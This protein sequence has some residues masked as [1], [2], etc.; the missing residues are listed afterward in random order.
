MSMRSRDLR[1]GR[2]L[3]RSRIPVDAGAAR[4]MTIRTIAVEDD[5]RYRTS[6]EILLEHAPEFQLVR[7]YASSFEAL[8]TLEAAVR[9][10]RASPWD[11]VLMDLDLPQLGGIEC[12]R[13]M[14]AL[15]PGLTIVV[16]TVLDQEAAILEAIC[17]GADGY[18]VKR[19]PA[20]Q[21]LARLREVMDGGS[22]L[23]AGVARTLLDLVRDA[24][25]RSGRRPRPALTLTPR[26]QDVLR[27]LVEGMSYAS[28]ATHL[29]VS[30][31]TIRTHVRSIYAKLQVHSVAGAVSRALR[32]RLI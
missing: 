30:V 6:L 16:L 2:I 8:G 32:E 28:A 18:L 22:P 31:D 15:Q 20:D 13:R 23:S 3:D 4:P 24:G 27:C 7:T 10:G 26:E 12:T 17:A 14:K 5:A 11:L 25:P 29:D 1:S 9:A 19:T 21:L